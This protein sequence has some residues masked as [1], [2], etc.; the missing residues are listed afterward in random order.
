M[1]NLFN[2][3][4]IFKSNNKNQNTTFENSDTYTKFMEYYAPAYD[5][6]LQAVAKELK[7]R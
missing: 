1:K 2:F 6:T 7:N 3:V 5:D 4:N